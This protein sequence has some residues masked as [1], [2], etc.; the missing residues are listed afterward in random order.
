MIYIDDSYI[1][2]V[3]APQI[4]GASDDLLHQ[5]K[6]NLELEQSQTTPYT[7]E[8]YSKKKLFLRSRCFVFYFFTARCVFDWFCGRL[9]VHH[10]LNPAASEFYFVFR[11]LS[12][13]EQRPR[14]IKPSA[15]NGPALLSP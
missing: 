10:P 15:T 3:S 14:N 4:S 2:I 9:G 13:S 7:L 12:L 11:S 1:P 8:Y 6:K 5:F